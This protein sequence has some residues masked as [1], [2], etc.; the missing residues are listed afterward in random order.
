MQIKVKLTYMF[1]LE[2]NEN[3]KSSIF[4]YDIMEIRKPPA[5]PIHV[6]QS[7]LCVQWPGQGGGG[8]PS[9]RL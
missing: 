8:R 7:V 3:L 5:F 2:N 4:D 6:L 9:P 1:L